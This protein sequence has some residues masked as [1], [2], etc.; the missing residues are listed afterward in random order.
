MRVV[1]GTK[2]GGLIGT[3]RGTTS[4]SYAANGILSG[5]TT[6]YGGFASEIPQPVSTVN[7]DWD[8]DTSGT[9]QGTAA[10]NRP[11]VTGLTTAQLTATLPSGFDSAVWGQSPT[12]N[13]GLPY[14]LANPPH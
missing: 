4:T 10:G 12:I 8:T 11:G 2:A 1:A 13:R 3:A 5:S 9:Q 6:A 7:D 14:L